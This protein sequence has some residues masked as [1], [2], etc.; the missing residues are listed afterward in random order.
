MVL[1]DIR[2]RANRD[3]H[4]GR[5]QCRGVGHAISHHRD[6]L[7]SALELLNLGGFILWQ[8]LGEDGVDS[9]TKPISRL[10]RPRRKSW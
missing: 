1:S 8:H 9:A 5:H 3:A 6:L 2:A 4:V 10:I 7:A